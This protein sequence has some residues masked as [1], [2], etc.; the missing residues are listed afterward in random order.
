M[1]SGIC[2]YYTEVNSDIY[3]RNGSNAINVI[4]YWNSTFEASPD[5]YK[6]SYLAYTY[7]ITIRDVNYSGNPISIIIGIIVA[8]L[9]YIG[10]GACICFGV[11]LNKKP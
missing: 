3:V 8:I 2:S 5:W 11:C 9:I 10:T 1:W 6:S 7:P 4:N